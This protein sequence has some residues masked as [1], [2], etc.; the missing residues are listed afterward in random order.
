MAGLAILLLVARSNQ[1]PVEPAV[2]NTSNISKTINPTAAQT[3]TPIPIATKP[4]ISTN[5]LAPA[6]TS[7]STPETIPGPEF[8]N[9]Y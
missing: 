5:T 7:T 2:T 3:E 9:S 1:N 8:Q 6:T 4:S